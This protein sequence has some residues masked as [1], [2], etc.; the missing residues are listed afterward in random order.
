[1]PA[2]QRRERKMRQYQLDER[3]GLDRLKLVEK[4]DPT[5]GENDLVIRMKAGSL[6]YRDLMQSR[7]AYGSAAPAGLVPLSDGAGE[8]VSVGAR[9][10]RFKARDRVCPL[11]FP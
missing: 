4:P 6:N 2:A 8:V 11:F 1:M 5:P 3:E 10:T 7:G 9:V